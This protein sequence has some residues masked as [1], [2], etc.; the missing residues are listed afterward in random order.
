MYCKLR[1]CPTKF[2]RKSTP[3]Y[4]IWPL[5]PYV[6]RFKTNHIGKLWQPYF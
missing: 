5:E 3:L 4:Y 1:V 2:V 6:N